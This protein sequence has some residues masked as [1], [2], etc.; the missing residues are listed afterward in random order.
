LTF[1]IHDNCRDNSYMQISDLQGFIFD[2]DGVIF[3]GNEFI[4][5]AKIG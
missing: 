1:D 4:E 3:R 2:I 5:G